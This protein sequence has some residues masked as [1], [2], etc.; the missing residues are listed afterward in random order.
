MTGPFETEHEVR[1]SQAA[2]L[3]HD[4]AGQLG[5]SREAIKSHNLRMLLDAVNSAGVQV[6]AYD[7]EILEWLAA[8]EPETCV[9]IA[10]LIARAAEPL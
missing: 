3:I 2:R 7:L 1:E 8:A 9:V 5:G 6:G 10:S 4:A